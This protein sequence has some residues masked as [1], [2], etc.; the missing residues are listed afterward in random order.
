MA[1]LPGGA[2]SVSRNRERGA[3]RAPLDAPEVDL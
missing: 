1:F 2:R 3:L